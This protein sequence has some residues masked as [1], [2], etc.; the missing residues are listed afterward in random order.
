MLKGLSSL[1][2]RQQG[3]A[4]LLL[5]RLQ[6]AGFAKKK[7]QDEE[8]SNDPKTH[9]LLKVSM[10]ASVHATS[11][12]LCRESHLE[13]IRSFNMNALQLSYQL[14]HHH[15]LMQLLLGRQP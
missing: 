2:H 1:A 6:A 12:D 4:K 7:G 14:H 9:R 8:S 10:H 11:A 15:L 5:P 13:L 3:C